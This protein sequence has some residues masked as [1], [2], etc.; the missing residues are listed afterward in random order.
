MQQLALESEQR[1]ATLAQSISS[2]SEAATRLSTRQRMASAKD[3]EGRD[4]AVR[5]MQTAV[6]ELHSSS[7]RSFALIAQVSA[8]SVNLRAELAVT[9]HSFSV[10]ADFAQAISRARAS[11]EQVE[12]KHPS[13]SASERTEAQ[14]ELADFATHYTMQAERD[15][16]QD[17]T[18]T[19]LKVGHQI[20]PTRALTVSPDKTAEFGD[21]IEL[22]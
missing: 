3:H 4:G 11:L 20:G 12:E 5:K 6:A 13:Y 9:R 2:M 16:H 14:R 7:E 22:F 8:R 10:G 17:V 15:V 21:N 1:S 19:T 18:K